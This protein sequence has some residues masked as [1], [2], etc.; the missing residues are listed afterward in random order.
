MTLSSF[1]CTIFTRPCQQDSASHSI[2]CVYAGITLHIYYKSH[3][4]RFDY[5]GPVIY[6]GQNQLLTRWWLTN[7]RKGL[8]NILTGFYMMQSRNLGLEVRCSAVS[9]SF[10]PCLLSSFMQG[11]CIAASRYASPHVLH[12]W[13]IARSFISH[14]RWWCMNKKKSL[15]NVLASLGYN[16]RPKSQLRSQM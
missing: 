5:T 16:A 13:Y 9:M 2:V 3:Y 15:Y 14:Y 7:K 6:L 11:L 8:C 10:C 12:V 4:R 1:M